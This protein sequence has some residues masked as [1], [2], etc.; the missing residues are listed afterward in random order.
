MGIIFARSVVTQGTENKLS[1]YDVT[2]I[3]VCTETRWKCGQMGLQ[4]SYTLKSYIQIIQNQCIVNLLSDRLSF[5]III[6][7]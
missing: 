2:D 4:L 1:S 5:D 3:S 7:R 6:I